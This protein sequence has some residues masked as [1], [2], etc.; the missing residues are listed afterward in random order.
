MA[1]P[2]IKIQFKPYLE[3]G[4]RRKWFI[5]IPFVFCIISSFGVYKHLPKAYKSTTTILVQAAK[6]PETFIRSTL[7]DSITE[8]LNTISQEILSRSRLEKI[9]N[10]FNLHE[11]LLK[12]NH[13]EEI[14]EK[15]RKKVEVKVQRQNSFSV[16]FEGEDPRTVMMVTN[17]LAALFIEENLRIREVRVGGTADFIEKELQSM[18]DR[19]KK[20]EYELRIYKERNL[21]QLPQQLD[22]NLRILDQLQQRLKTTSENLRATEDRIISLQDQIEEMRELQQH[23]NEL[24]SPLPSSQRSGTPRVD[25]STIQRTPEDPMI[26]QLNA[27]KRDLENTRSKYTENHPDVIDLKRK[28][29]KLEPRVMELLRKEE[30]NIRQRNEA[31]VESNLDRPMPTRSSVDPTVERRITQYREQLKENQIVAKRLNEEVKSLGEQIL[32]YQRRVEDTPKREQEM[33]QLTRDYD[34]LKLNYQSLLD[35]KLQAQMAESLE[36]KQQG[37]QFIILDPARIPEKPISPDRNKVL[38]VGSIIGLVAG[39]GLAWFREMLDK[40]FHTASDLEENLGIH[41][42]ATIP[43][44]KE[45]IE[46]IKKA[47]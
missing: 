42:L 25:V 26:T 34:L 22:A 41:V 28:I 1:N 29:A 31:I 14:I 16:S 27:L 12:K 40:S 18:E 44:L 30:E 6:V 17:K 24:S 9:I 36:R 23:Q 19:L 32:H 13:M 47:A 15:M 35:K 37:E 7:T 39:L 38:L 45:E 43:N 20:K 21:G 33:L 8:R 10:E 4:L 2:E 3:I 5:I 46:K 11:D